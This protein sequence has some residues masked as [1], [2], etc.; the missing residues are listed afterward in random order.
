MYKYGFFVLVFCPFVSLATSGKPQSLHACSAVVS[1]FQKLKS[2]HQEI[3]DTLAGLKEKAKTNESLDLI[4]NSYIQ[5]EHLDHTLSFYKE[6]V[7]TLGDEPKENASKLQALMHDG[8]F[9][10]SR[11]KKVTDLEK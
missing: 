11:L 7:K 10:L 2:Q 5:Q 1:T 3:E 8:A 6:K 4:L 9:I